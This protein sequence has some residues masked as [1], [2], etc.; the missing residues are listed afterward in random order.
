MAAVERVLDYH[1]RSR[2]VEKPSHSFLFREE[3]FRRN[4]Q[5]TRHSYRQ[6]FRVSAN[7]FFMGRSIVARFKTFSREG[8]VRQPSGIQ[9]GE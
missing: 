6:I 3:E 2:I 5:T 8:E 7:L 9:T 4:D 1:R